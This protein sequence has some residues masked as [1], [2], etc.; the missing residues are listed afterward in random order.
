MQRLLLVLVLADFDVARFETGLVEAD[1]E[2]FDYPG[3]DVLGAAAGP[4]LGQVAAE[5]GNAAQALPLAAIPT[6]GAGDLAARLEPDQSRH[7]LDLEPM[8]HVER[9]IVDTSR[10]RLRK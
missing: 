5:P 8:R 9:G 3:L 7:D 2:A 6:V 10:H 1:F 4:R